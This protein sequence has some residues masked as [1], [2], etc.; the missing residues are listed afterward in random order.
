MANIK[1]SGF[2]SV[3]DFTELVGLQFSDNGRIT[4]AD[5][6]IALGIEAA[7]SSIVSLESAVSDITALDNQGYIGILSPFYFD[8]AATST[9]I[10]IEEVDVWQDVIMEIHANGVS[11]E[12]VTAMKQAQTVGYEGDGTLN[13]PIVFLLEGLVES[14]FC[15]LRT[16]LSFTPDEDGGRLDS[17]LFIERHIGAGD[18]FSI[19]AAGLSMESGADEIYPHL[20]STEFFIGDTIDTNGVGD[21]GKVRFQIKSDVTGTVSMNEMALFI[22]R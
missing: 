18:D 7:E 13:N 15:T 20:I 3:T 19:N 2:P 17:R 21:A 1:F 9:E 22:N 12:R 16:S 10:V 14:S 6:R 11:D 5:L 4:K 8:G